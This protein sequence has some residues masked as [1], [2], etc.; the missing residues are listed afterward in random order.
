MFARNVKLKTTSVC[1]PTCNCLR[2]VP[3]NIR[4]LLL[5]S[6]VYRRSVPSGNS[7]VKEKCRCRANFESL[8]ASVRA[9]GK[10]ALRLVLNGL[11]DRVRREG[12]GQTFNAARAARE[13]AQSAVKY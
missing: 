9:I 13:Q 3:G 7:D 11:S 10:Q 4:G 8:L 2:A 12:W 1:Q 6:R 5:L